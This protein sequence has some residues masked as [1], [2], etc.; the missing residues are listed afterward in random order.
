MISRSE[1]I[2]AVRDVEK[3]VAFYRDVLGGKGEWLWGEPP[4]FAG[5]R[6]GEVQLMFN[7]QPELA[8][9]IEGH[10]HY[11]FAEDVDALHAQHAAADAPI[12]S[13][14]ENKPWGIREYTVRDPDGYHL[15]FAGPAEFEKPATA[16]DTM[17]GHV[18]VEPRLP[19]Y[20]EYQDLKRSVGWDTQYDTPE[21]LAGCCAGVVAVDRNTGQAVGMARAVRDAHLW[22]SVWDVV[23]RPEYQAQRIGSAVMEMLL[24]R[25]RQTEPAG[26]NVVLFTY[27][28]DFY[29]RMGFKNETCSMV[30]L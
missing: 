15:R 5:V 8:A 29:A 26:S 20:A 27:S 30:K 7:R 2:F 19:S 3:A 4:T 13:P 28:P 12:V 24:A 14:I 16:V 11:L 9:A 18:T 1:P 23:V 21:L 22:Y 25:L 6:L 10:E 17:P